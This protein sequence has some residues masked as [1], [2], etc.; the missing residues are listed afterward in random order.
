MEWWNKKGEHGLSYS[1]SP[2]W[3]WVRHFINLG[4]ILY[5]IFFGQF[6]YNQFIYF[7]F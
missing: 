3:Q 7:Q 5:I 1:I 2:S 6:G 4:L